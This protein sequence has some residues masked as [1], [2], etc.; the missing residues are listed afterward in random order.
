MKASLEFDLTIKDDNF[1]D[2]HYL[3]SIYKQAESLYS[4]LSEYSDYLRS[5]TKHKEYNTD[6]EYDL[7]DEFKERFH[8][9]LSEN[10]VDIS[11]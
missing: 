2:D 9:I 10:N 11:L 3:Y 7:A 6:A 1:T 5:M 4:A 8:D